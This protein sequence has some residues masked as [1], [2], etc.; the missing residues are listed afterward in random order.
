MSVDMYTQPKTLLILH[1]LF[2][3]PFK[4]L[5]RQQY[6]TEEEMASNQ[7]DEVDEEHLS[8]VEQDRHDDALQPHSYAPFKD[9]TP[10]K[11]FKP[12]PTV[13]GTAA[14]GRELRHVDVSQCVLTPVESEFDI[15]GRHVASQL[16]QLKLEHAVTAIGDI[17]N[18]LTQKRLASLY[19]NTNTSKCGT[20]SSFS[21][22]QDI[23]SPITILTSSD[24]AEQV[25]T[26]Q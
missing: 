4:P 26:K 19:E 9:R 2:Q 17:S 24:S 23:M 6:W 12:Q 16:K 18:I 15:F 3:V 22:T 11:R 5:K 21:N 25:V 14:P 10:I 7:T 8:M 1:C 20:T 13:E